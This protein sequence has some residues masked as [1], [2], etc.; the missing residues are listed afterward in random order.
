M[1]GTPYNMTF[2]Y[3]ILLDRCVIV[4][5]QVS[6]VSRVETFICQGWTRFLLK[7]TTL[8]SLKAHWAPNSQVAQPPLRWDGDPS[9]KASPHPKESQLWF[10]HRARPVHYRQLLWADVSD[11]DQKLNSK[12]NNNNKRKLAFVCAQRTTT[13]KASTT[14]P[15]KADFDWHRV[16]VQSST[17]DHLGRMMLI[18]I[19]VFTKINRYFHPLLF[20]NEFCRSH[21]SLSSITILSS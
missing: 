20:S 15:R 3:C 2:V 21:S 16:C 5:R 18:V 7:L 11:N 1:L 14:T 17:S 9:I 6:K 13:T 10:A 19:V 12:N 4:H 8:F